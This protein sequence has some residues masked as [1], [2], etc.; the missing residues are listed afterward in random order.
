MNEH[1]EPLFPLATRI[2]D[3]PAARDRPTSVDAAK[4][5]RLRAPGYRERVLAAIQHGSKTDEEI[6]AHTGLRGNTVRPRRLE[7]LRALKIRDSGQT[8][9]TSSGREAVIW[10]AIP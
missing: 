4:R 3:P 1:Q 8:R 2:P 10:E 5:V 9:V 6:E 7:L